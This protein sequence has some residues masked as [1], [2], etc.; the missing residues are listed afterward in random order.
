[1]RTIVLCLTAFF[2]WSAALVFMEGPAGA[3]CLTIASGDGHKTVCSVPVRDGAVIYLDFINPADLAP[4]RETFQYRSGEGLRMTQVRSPSAGVLQSCGARPGPDNSAVLDRRPGPFGRNEEDV[5]A[6][7]GE[8]L[9]RFGIPPVSIDSGGFFGERGILGE[10]I[11]AQSGERLEVRWE[12]FFPRYRLYYFPSARQQGVVIGECRFPDGCNNG[13]FFG[14]DADGD[15]LPDSFRLVQWVS[16]DY[17]RD[18]EVPGYLDRYRYIY[19]VRQDKYYLWH[20][21]LIYRC[22]PPL[23]VPP[24]TCRT[25]CDPPYEVRTVGDK[26]YPRI[27]KTDLIEERHL[28]VQE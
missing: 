17:G 15:G 7:E 12:G 11:R 27:F 8:G 6:L 25:T 5:D 4:V 10:P 19:D 1:M 28:L 14:P 20:D 22:A 16:S 18:D 21:L 2:V 9:K 13:F 23:S 26:T 3:A 24:D